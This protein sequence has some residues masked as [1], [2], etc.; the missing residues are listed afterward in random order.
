MSTKKVETPAKVQVDMKKSLRVSKKILDLLQKRTKS[1]TEAYFAVRL[2][3]I[4]LEEKLG[5][6]MTAEQEDELKTLA[7]RHRGVRQRSYQLDR[8]A[9]PLFRQ[10]LLPIFKKPCEQ[11]PNCQR[12][13]SD[14]EQ[15]NIRH[16]KTRSNNDHSDTRCDPA[17]LLVSF[18]LFNLTIKPTQHADF[19]LWV[20]G[21]NVLMLTL[22]RTNG[23]F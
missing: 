4:F 19:L 8:D 1:S 15:S 23:N 18:C 20:T 7:E 21:L 12:H 13:D 22:S 14:H 17:N 9:F 16:E 3:G 5:F 2:V 10:L 6:K 11:S